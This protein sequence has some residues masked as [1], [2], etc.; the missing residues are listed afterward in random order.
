MVM[1]IVISKD[2]LQIYT[3]KITLKGIFEFINVIF[4]KQMSQLPNDFK[5]HRFSTPTF[6][7]QIYSVYLCTTSVMY[8]CIV[9]KQRTPMNYYVPHICIFI[10][11]YY[12]VLSLRF[13]IQ[14]FN[15]KYCTKFKRSPINHVRRNKH[16][17]LRSTKQL[18]VSLKYSK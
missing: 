17:N 7:L 15:N 5:C 14:L 4:H 6:V 2:S 12:S 1:K 16:K 11:T 8:L 3:C 9:P 18:H 13:P 10:K